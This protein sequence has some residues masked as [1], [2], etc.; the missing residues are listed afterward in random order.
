MSALD[1]GDGVGAAESCSGIEHLTRTSER[2]PLH[3]ASGVHLRLLHLSRGLRA[4]I[5]LQRGHGVHAPGGW[6]SRHKR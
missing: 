6:E 1:P 4:A 5:L 3:P 2:R